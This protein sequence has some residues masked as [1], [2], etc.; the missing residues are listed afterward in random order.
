M[1]K[2][3][4]LSKVTGSAMVFFLLAA[5][6]AAAAPSEAKEGKEHSFLVGLT[7]GVAAKA[8]DAPGIQMKDRWDDLNVVQ[9]VAS[10]AA[11]KGLE[12]NPNISYI[13]EDRTVYASSLGTNYTDGA[14]TWGLQAVNAEQ[15]WSQNAT[16]QNIKVCVLDSGIDYDHPEF[17][18]D[19]VSVIKASKNFVNDGHPDATDG[20]GHG[21]HVAGTI[22]G[23]TS[24]SGSRIGVAPDVDLYVARVLGDDGS[25]STSG[26]INALSWCQ[27]NNANIA[28]LSLGSSRS[29]RTEKAAFDKAY[30]NG[31]LSIAASGNDGGAIGYPANYSSVVAVGAVD[32][33]LNL[34]S[35]SNYGKNQEV[36]APGVATLSSIP[37]G[38]GIQSSAK[39]TENGVDTSF[40]S[41]P[42]EFSGQGEVTGAL[43]DSGLGDSADAFSGKPASGPWV[44]LINRGSISFAE[45][46]QNAVAQGASAVIIANNDTANPDD[47]G[48]FTL[49]SEGNWVPV[50]SVSYNSGNS[51]RSNGLGTGSVNVSS[52]DYSYFQG[53]S[54]ATPHV[55]AVAALAWSANPQL[56]NEQI[57]NILQSTA[58]DLG[59]A[60]RDSSFGFG[61][62]QADAAVQKARNF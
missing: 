38:T 39:E 17:T 42:L 30:Q 53:T 27:Q 29:S 9:I 4:F 28:S 12:H 11:I 21:T 62:V 41:V 6:L 19:G 35:F 48:S 57:R 15:A 55:S 32:S 59:T 24:N 10:E 22:V 51:I 18:R 33:S 20:A 13:E 25:G 23:Q 52:W 31:M 36:V 26:I 56:T 7:P 60:G 8:L 44:A 1:R 49:G 2:A 3:G 37:R 50:V 54:M 46:I 43:V 61:L 5:N 16:G 14:L 40:S 34:A 58:V 47:P 45:K